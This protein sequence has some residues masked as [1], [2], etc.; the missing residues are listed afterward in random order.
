MSA[1]DLHVEGMGVLGS[2]LA[3]H[4]TASGRA[5]TW[6][7]TDDPHA[8]WPA[9][10]GLVYPDGDPDAAAD[11]ATWA[12]WSAAGL[13][14]PDELAP[15]RFVY[16]QKTRP[17]G[18]RYPTLGLGE[19]GL[20]M[21]LADC[22]QVDPARLVG[23]VRTEN[24]A[25]RTQSTPGGA[26]VVRAHARIWR[27]TWGW[28]APVRLDTAR[29]P[30]LGAPPAFH[31]RRISVNVYAYPLLSRPGWWRAGSSLYDQRHPRPLDAAAHLDR[32]R[33]DWAARGF[34]A[35]PVVETGEPVQGW[36]PRPAPDDPA[37]VTRDPDG[38]LRIPALWHSGVRR[39]PTVIAA[40]LTALASPEET[41]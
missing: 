11:L 26:T 20:T 30:D 31:G 25:S 41:P 29:L 37:T 33:A 22:W 21:A 9:S 40:L 13:F 28:S 5:F 3:R 7:D 12:A 10:T 36:R 32:W 24:A 18:G 2:V 39:A 14:A 16:A 8:A 38:A 1:A 6:S 19:C 15:A 23:N 27:H 4:L 35:V 34:W 17:H